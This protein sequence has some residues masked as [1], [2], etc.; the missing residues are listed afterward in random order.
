[1][2]LKDRVYT[3]QDAIVLAQQKIV[4]HKLLDSSD[5]LELA[6]MYMKAGVGLQIPEQILNFISPTI[7]VNEK[8]LA[9]ILTFP[10]FE[11]EKHMATYRFYRIEPLVIRDQVVVLPSKFFALNNSTTT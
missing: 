1:M 8:T 11:P 9:Y 4:S 5:V 2:K 10:T 6:N 3:I 7:G